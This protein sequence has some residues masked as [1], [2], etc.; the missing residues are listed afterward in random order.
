MPAVKWR[1]CIQQVILLQDMEIA[2]KALQAYTEEC[3][4]AQLPA[5]CQAREESE[6]RLEVTISTLLGQQPSL[7]NLP[8]PPP[9]P[10]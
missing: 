3:K 10:K 8:P 2:A 5:P 6:K 4:K 9:L 7:P 1:M